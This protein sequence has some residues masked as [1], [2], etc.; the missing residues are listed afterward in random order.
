MNAPMLPHDREYH[1][2]DFLETLLVTDLTVEGRGLARHEG[3]VVFLDRGLPGAL[4]SA[5]VTVVKKR[6]IEA[7][8]HEVIRRSPHAVALWC[9]HAKECGACLWQHFS[10][11]SALDWK[12]GHVRE[13]LARIAKITDVEVT[14]VQP[15]PKV[16]EYRNKMAFAFSRTPDGASL[17]GLRKRKEHSIVEVTQCGLQPAPAMDI[18]ACIRKAV[19][20]LGLKAFS[21]NT[22]GRHQGYLRFLVI[23]TPEYRPGGEQQ[24]L[25]ECITGTNHEHETG[26]T[27]Q[28]EKGLANAESVRLIGEELMESFTLTGFVH[29]ERKQNSEVAQGERLVRQIGNARYEERFGHLTLTVPHNVFLQTN[30]GAAALLYERIA[31]EAGLD[32]SQTVWDLYSGIGSIALYLA[33]KAREVYGLEIQADAV[34]AAQSNSEVLGFSH[35]R[36]YQGVLTHEMARHMPPPDLIVLDPPRA[37]IDERARETLLHLPKARRMLYV[38]CDV[39]TQARDLAVL[40]PVWKAVRSFPVDMFPNTPHVENLVVLEHQ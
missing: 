8:V 27:A 3:M 18:L 31:H 11:D 33:P 10:P 21:R 20:R 13:T 12:R 7:K 19:T 30:T 25:V 36:F 28:G 35:C 38:S 34:I 26:L 6:V 32:G 23:H 22:E 37:G 17:L 2:G 14:P 29:S 39:A 5:Y 40:A 9:P 15:S 1:P 16:R 24:V 4:V